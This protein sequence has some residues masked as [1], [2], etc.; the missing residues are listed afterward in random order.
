MHRPQTLKARISYYQ[1]QARMLE[2]SSNLRKS[3]N[4]AAN[5]YTEKFLLNLPKEPAFKSGDGK[6]IYD[7]GF[8]EKPKNINKILRIVKENIETP[9]LNSASGNYF[10][11]IPGSNLYTSALG[12]F[13]ADV[14]NR[15]TCFYAL[16]P[17]AVCLENMIIRW[18]SQLIRFP[19]SAAGNLTSDGSMANLTAMIAARDAHH[20]LQY[21]AEK[22]VIYLSEQTHHCVEKALHLMGL[23]HVVLHFLPL[24]ENFKIE[25]E[26]VEK[27]IEQDKKLGLVPW[28]IV[29]TAGTTNTGAI[30]PL[31]KLAA[32][33][34]SHHLWFH[35]DAAYGGFFILTQ[36]GKKLLKGVAKAD[37]IVLDPHKSLFLPYGLG[38][39]L[40]RNY[41]NLLHSF[42]HDAHYIKDSRIKTDEL[43]P[44]DLSTELSRPFRG[45][46]MWLPL[47]LH[48]IAPFRAALEEKLLLAQYFAQEVKKIK[49][50]ELAC[51]PQLSIVAFRYLPVKQNADTFNLRLQ[52]RIKKDGRIYLSSTILRGQVYLRFACLS[53]RTHKDEVDKAIKIL[54]EMIPITPHPPLRGDLSRKGRGRRKI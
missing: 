12:D 19:K 1:R 15:V 8:S 43:S 49:G 50:I 52:K 2:P 22:V 3:Y 10:A 26:A 20:I 32:I 13:I 34:K 39:V 9:G 45:L 33:A 44:A 25:A 47:Q 7:F 17:G 37:S 4:R 14:M 5:H 46:R 31:T 21:P 16:S 38:I 23:D 11:Y 41:K 24:D 42:M 54:K 27:L 30:D 40:V 48:G 53:Y 28:M 51:E 36:T 6:K 18:L 35:I 29:A